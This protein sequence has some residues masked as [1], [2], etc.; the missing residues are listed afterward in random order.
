MPLARHRASLILGEMRR[1]VAPMG[2]PRKK[3][4]EA[5]G[6][7]RAHK[8]PRRTVSQVSEET[9]APETMAPTRRGLDDGEG[10]SKGSKGNTVVTRDLMTRTGSRRFPSQSGCGLTTPT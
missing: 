5:R 6:L 3:D 7:E 2:A 9:K 1:A 8:A 4:R 10:K